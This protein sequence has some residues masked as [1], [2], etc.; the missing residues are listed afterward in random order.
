MSL[1]IV[2]TA[3]MREWERLTWASGQTEAAVIARVGGKV[4]ARALELTAEGDRILLAA[5]KGHNGDDVRAALPQLA[6]R[7]PQLVEAPDAAE[8]AARLAEALKTR[9]ALIVDGLFGIGLNR[10]LSQEWIEVI[11]RINASGA[12]VLSVDLPSGLDADTGMTHGAAIRATVTLTVGAPKPGLLAANAWEYT[13]RV[14]VARDVGLADFNPPTERR[15]TDPEDFAAWPPRRL[16]ASHKGSHGH[17][18]ILA[19]SLGYHG[20][21]VLAAR[22]AQ[23]AQPGLIT[24][25]TMESSYLPIA[26][27]CQAVMVSVWQPGEKLL[28]PWSAILIGPGLA[29][30]DVPDEAR[31]LARLLWRDSPL[32]VVVDASALD[33]LPLSPGPRNSI[34]V[35]TPHPGEAARLLRRAPEQVQADR[36]GA[37]RQLSNRFGQCWVVLKGHQTLIGRGEGEVLVNSSGNPYLAQ[38]GSGDVLSGYIAG[39]LAQPSARQDPLRA[40]SYAVY[41]HGAAADRWQAARAGWTVEDLLTSLGRFSFP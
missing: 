29:G 22:G 13:G 34:R 32:P 12:D 17:L 8:G 30:A 9:P 19:G 35:M 27:Q 11:E 20:A 38:G 23:R 41:E 15:W 5:G 31:A 28:G 40:L 2:S 25:Q 14:E 37:L 26:A 3:Q 39:W 16:V 7:Q 18:L 10:P 6:K 4:A 33:W 36:L 24:V 21:A 1:P